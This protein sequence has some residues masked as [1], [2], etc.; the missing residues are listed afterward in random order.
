M[1]ERWASAR[2]R[3]Y[4]D[5]FDTFAEVSNRKKNIGTQCNFYCTVFFKHSPNMILKEGSNK[6]TKEQVLCKFPTSRIQFS[7]SPITGMRIRSSNYRLGWPLF[8]CGDKRF[9]YTALV[10]QIR[11]VCLA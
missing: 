4:S 7:S 10:R 5:N 1:I 3:L 6:T 9:I 8:M 2:K 11:R